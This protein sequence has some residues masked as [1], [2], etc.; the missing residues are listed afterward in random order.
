MLSRTMSETTVRR[1]RP[2]VIQHGLIDRPGYRPGAGRALVGAREYGAVVRL[3][4]A[5]DRG[6]GREARRPGRDSDPAPSC[7][8]ASARRSRARALSI[9]S[10]LMGRLVD[11][12]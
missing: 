11:E 9:P 3:S 2:E 5:G 6:A 12:S 1:S 8:P 10:P 7:R 4:P